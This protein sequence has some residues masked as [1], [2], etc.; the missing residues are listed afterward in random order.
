[1]D[2]ALF[3]F[4]G[5]ITRTDAFSGSDSFSRFVRY[6]VR[7]SRCV[8]GWL[9]LGPVVLG[10]RLRWV[11][12]SRA[13]R[14]VIRVGFWAESPSRVS[15]LGARFATEVLPMTLRP[16]AVE[17]IHWHQGR[18][19][20]VVVVSAALDV[21]LRPWCEAQGVQCICTELEV[22]NGL[23]TGGYLN[24]DCTGAEKVRRVVMLYP[25]DRYRT[26]YAYGDTAEDREML[27]LANRKYYCWREVGGS[28][29]ASE[30]TGLQ[31]N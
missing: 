16:R 31:A 30:G 27:E 17:R 2:L 19:D 8:I 12:A 6:A 15:Q 7:P 26:I 11:S 23:L 3:D 24:G 1:M 14:A 22:R 13:R 25:P 21:Y 29:E 20:D 9:L 4:D 5:T 18:G 10:C 28:A